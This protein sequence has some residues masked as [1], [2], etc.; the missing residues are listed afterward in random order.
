MEL[1]MEESGFKTYV[2][3]RMLFWTSFVKLMIKETIQALS[4]VL[5]FD[6]LR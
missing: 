5:P 6:L 1:I 2:F 4:L 3:Q